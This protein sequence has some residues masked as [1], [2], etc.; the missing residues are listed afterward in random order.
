MLKSRAFLALAMMGIA[1]PAFADVP[2]V[3]P[4]LLAPAEASVP[5]VRQAVLYKFKLHLTASD[6]FAD[7]LVQL[8]VDGDDIEKAMDL[9]A[10]RLGDGKQSCDV[11]LEVSR[12]V[13]GRSLSLERATVFTSAGNTV[14]ERRRGALTVASRSATRKSVPLV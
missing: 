10:D 4:F 11:T 13:G 7:Q 12:S 3:I 9:A 8:G 2:D 6:A 5:A 14:L 1:S